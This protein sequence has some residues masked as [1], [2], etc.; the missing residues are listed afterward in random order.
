MGMAL[1]TEQALKWWSLGAWNGTQILCEKINTQKVYKGFW[2]NHLYPRHS[3]SSILLCNLAIILSV[4]WV[5]WFLLKPLRM[6]F[7][8]QMIGG[9]I[10]MGIL[11]SNRGFEY[12]TLLPPTVTFIL[13]TMSFIGFIFHLFMLGV[14]T[15]M[16]VI[17]RRLEKKSIA[18][19]F[20]GCIISLLFSIAAFLTTKIFKFSKVEHQMSDGIISLMCLNAQS[21]FMVTCN[22]L[23][24]LGI[25]N[26]DIGRLASTISL[27][28]DLLVMVTN[29]TK[30]VILPPIVSM[31]KDVRN[32]AIILGYY[33]L[34]FLV[35]RPL[36]MMVL[37]YTPQGGTMKNTHFMFIFLIVM[38]VAGLGEVLD[39]MFAVFL[40]ALSLPEYPLSSVFSEKL[41]AITSAVFFPVYCAVQGLQTNVYSLTK[42][43]LQFEFI[44]ILGYVGKFVGTTFSACL[45]GFPLWNSMALA[46]ILC[47]KGLLD[48]VSLGMWRDQKLLDIE[49]YTLA[50]FHFLILTGGLMPLV[51]RLY[52]PLS[53]YTSVFRQSVAESTSNGTF[54]TIVCLYK[55]EN[56]PG[57]LR[58]IEAF[59]PTRTR[60]IPVIALQLMPLFGR[61]TVPIMAP[62]DQVKSLPIFRPKLAYLNRVVEAFLNLERESK[63]YTRVKHYIALASLEGMHNDVCALAYEKDVSLLILPFHM[64]VQ[65]TKVGK[66]VED[67]S[68]S[69]REVNK[70]VLEKAPCS[71]GILLDRANPFQGLGDSYAYQVAII[72]LGGPDDKDA[73]AL[74][75]LFGTHPH[76]KVVVVWL[77]SSIKDEGD[78]AIEALN[79]EL[80]T[81]YKAPKPPPNDNDTTMKLKEVVVNDGADTTNLLLSMNGVVDLVVVGRHHDPTCVPL[82]GLSLDGWREYPELGI[83]GDLLATPDF[84][85]SVLVVQQEPKDDVVGAVKSTGK[86]NSNIEDE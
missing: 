64:N 71:V 21:F 43:S 36:V 83:L 38:F 66:I 55:E 75:S 26:S 32:S 76:V 24:D 51:R 50:M 53:Q 27:L 34:I 79:Y 69:I 35:F 31:G 74:T 84:G 20:S 1:I 11:F 67:G 7:T 68:L 47:S 19:G 73:L 86:F 15:N 10:V 49:E 46:L 30:Y 4:T 25:S 12:H 2:E 70:M 85:F 44:L 40:F 45:F 13:K 60:P 81:S 58:L 78:D 28:L 16:T 6:A 29:F 22:N 80:I 42:R 41:D 52:E 63:G 48:I 56:L 33:A 17:I 77:K 3:Y 5:T 9:V 37:R 54:Q 62:L 23:N 59:N 82:Y 57:T 14:E 61:C 72:F 18:I 39:E 8:S 65:W